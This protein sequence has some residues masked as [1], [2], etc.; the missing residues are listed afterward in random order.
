MFINLTPASLSVVIISLCA[1]RILVSAGKFNQIIALTC[2]YPEVLL[3]RHGI[4][5]NV[6]FVL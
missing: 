6:S 1:G 5:G 3:H 2:L 4:V